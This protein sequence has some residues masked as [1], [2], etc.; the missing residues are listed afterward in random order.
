MKVDYEA[1][2]SFFKILFVSLSQRYQNGENQLLPIVVC[3]TP[4]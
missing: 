3:K 4:E 1:I 2:L